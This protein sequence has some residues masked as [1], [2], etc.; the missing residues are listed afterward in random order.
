LKIEETFFVLLQ[1]S[2]L[3]LNLIWSLIWIFCCFVLAAK[4]TSI[5]FRTSIGKKESDDGD[6][7]DCC[8]C[9]GFDC[10]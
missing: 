4:L 1:R 5:C 9:L 2:V 10:V 6:C 7:C 8:N 3:E